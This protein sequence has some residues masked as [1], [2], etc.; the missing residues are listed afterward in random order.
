[1]KIANTVEPEWLEAIKSL[2]LDFMHK[3]PK[4]ML[5]HLQ[6]GGTELDDDDIPK[7]I[8]KL[9]TPWEVNENLAT[10]FAR[11]DKIKKRLT[12]KGIM[13]QPFVQLALA[14]SAFKAIGKYEVV[15]NIF[16]AKPT[17]NQTFANF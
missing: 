11:D 2:T 3:T 10:K 1:M 16:K 15:L 8:T 5:N 4:E 13:A 9:N 6:L 7:L 12:K 17:A 14:K